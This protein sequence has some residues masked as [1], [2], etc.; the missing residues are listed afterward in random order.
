MRKKITHTLFTAIFSVLM[1]QS[2]WSADL[3]EL[4]LR[5][6]LDEARGFCIDIRGHKKRAKVRQGLQ[7]HSCYSY[8]GEIGV[9]QAFDGKLLEQGSFFMPAFDVCMEA[10]GRFENAKLTLKQC[11]GHDFQKFKLTQA[12]QIKLSGDRDFCVAIGEEKSRE[13]GGG[14]PPHLMR[15]LMLR[16][17]S[18][19]DAK[20]STWKVYELQ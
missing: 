14:N 4:Q 3:V 19:V 2:A 5:E 12:N 7:A 9:D 10:E 16:D 1:H 6:R 18:K 15:S 8:Q 20:Y 13:G 17:C 11:A